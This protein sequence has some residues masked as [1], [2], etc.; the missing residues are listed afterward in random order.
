MS[1][2]NVPEFELNGNPQEGLTE[3]EYERALLDRVISLS[4]GDIGN[5]H[6]SIMAALADEKM[7]TPGRKG[8][9]IR[10]LTKMA[11]QHFSQQH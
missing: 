10:V 2:I 3:K 11:K 5:V 7:G 8:Y 9:L 1:R 6:G 4:R